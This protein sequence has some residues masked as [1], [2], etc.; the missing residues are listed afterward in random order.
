MK[1]NFRDISCKM[2][3]AG[4]YVSFRGC[5]AKGRTVVTLTVGPTASYPMGIKVLCSGIKRSGHEAVHLFSIARVKNAWSL[6][7]T[8]H[9]SAWRMIKDQGQI[10][11]HLSWNYSVDSRLRTTGTEH[12]FCLH[13]GVLCAYALSAPSSCRSGMTSIILKRI[14]L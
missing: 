13:D 10:C 6:P 7:S 2:R 4:F 11:L 5:P 14:W 8:P 1:K 12:F 9:T 3:D